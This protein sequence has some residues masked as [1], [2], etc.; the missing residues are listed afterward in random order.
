MK[1]LDEYRKPGLKEDVQQFLKAR[2]A[3]KI[4]VANARL[5]FEKAIKGCHPLDSM[6]EANSVIVFGVY[7]GSDYYRTIKVEGKT[8]S[9]D[10]IGYIFRD[11]LAYELAEF[12]KIRGFS[13]L[14]P[15]GHFDRQ[16]KIARL[17]FK[18][19]AH[20]AGLGV[21]GKSGLIITP[22]YGPRINI[23]V[24]VADVVLE[25]DNKLAFSPC[26]SCNVC[27]RVCPA[28]AIRDDFDPPASHNRETCVSFVQRLRDVTGDER[29]FCGY[30]YDKCPVGKTRKAGFQ[31]S[32][33]RKL[34]DLS[35]EE[36]GKLINEA[37]L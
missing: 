3:F 9:D 30:C 23:G 14:V 24:V 13:A 34:A 17:S 36:R 5:G 25:P 7:V 8:E 21:Y 2:G 22:E 16:R 31:F 20:E 4:R 1:T 10:R 27:A 33:Y 15:S 6:K 37:R 26:E 35:S 28:S 11:W 19:A 29:F 32:K 12:L 18:L